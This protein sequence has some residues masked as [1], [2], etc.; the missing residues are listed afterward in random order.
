MTTEDRA[1][2]ATAVADYR[3]AAANIRRTEANASFTLR[4]GQRSVDAH[5]RNARVMTSASITLRELG[6]AH[7]AD[8]LH[9]THTLLQEVAHAREEG[10]TRLV[11]SIND[12]L[13]ESRRVIRE[14]L[15]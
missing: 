13:S 6:L 10:R 14:A 3:R 1:K 4:H 15:R 2:A 8:A 5:A 7:V 12:E 9:K 11:A